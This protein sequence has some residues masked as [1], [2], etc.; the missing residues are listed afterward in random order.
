VLVA[1]ESAVRIAFNDVP[2][3]QRSDSFICP[4]IAFYIGKR[5]GCGSGHRCAG[6]KRTDSGFQY[7]VFHWMDPLIVLGAYSDTKI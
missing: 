4:G 7:G 5:V 2:V 3:R 1:A 6:K